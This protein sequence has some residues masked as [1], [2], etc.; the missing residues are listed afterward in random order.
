M[1]PNPPV[2]AQL[3]SGRLLVPGPERIRGDHE[4][5]SGPDGWGACPAMLRGERPACEGAVWCRA[6][7]GTRAWRFSFGGQRG[8]CPAALLN[9]LRTE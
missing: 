7:G 9:P 4:T 1:T 2:V 8:A 3:P 6:D 5:C